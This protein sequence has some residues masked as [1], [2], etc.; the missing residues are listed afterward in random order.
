MNILKV[1]DKG[2][3]NP[4]APRLVRNAVRAV[5]RR[6]DKLL[7]IKSEAEGYYKLPGGGI[8]REEDH[9]DALIREVDEET[10]YSV[11]ADTVKPL[12][13]IREIRRSLYDSDTFEQNSYI[14]TCEI[15]GSAGKTHMT[16]NEKRRRYI[17]GYFDISE[18]FNADKEISERSDTDFLLREMYV[19]KMLMKSDK[20]TKGKNKSG[21]N[22]GAILGEF[23][24]SENIDTYA[25][26]PYSSCKIINPCAAESLITKIGEPVSVLMFCVPYYTKLSD[27]AGI[28]RYAAARDYHLYFRLLSDRLGKFLNSRGACVKFAVTGDNSPID[29]RAAAMTC[30]LG[31]IGK[32]G[33][34]INSK[35]GS[36][37]FLCGIYFSSH[38]LLDSSGI[39]ERTE[40][41][42]CGKCVSECPGNALLLRDYTRCLSYISQKKHLDEGD[43]D[44]L[45]STGTVWGC[46]ICQNVCP[47]NSGIPETPI[48]FFRTDLIP[49]PTLENISALSHAGK[50]DDRAFAWRGRQTI[51]R[52]IKINTSKK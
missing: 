3:Y 20:Y 51:E 24:S 14:Y 25:V 10:G 7:L 39:S 5:I 38:I 37:I 35:Y 27:G 12:G 18:A 26:V 44:R 9:L 30:G 23:L 48:E 2:D 49:N 11:V 45:A 29:E 34:L 40:C 17:P 46:D 52:N 42:D 32:N 21:D 6:G 1:F 50:F 22:I 28:S 15:S 41:L 8:E 31:F 36:F 19:F 33:L 13:L 43:E 4:D 47:H 16:D